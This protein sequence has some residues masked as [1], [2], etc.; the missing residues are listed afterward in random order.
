VDDEDDAVVSDVTT[1]QRVARRV[2]N[3]LGDDAVTGLRPEREAPHLWVGDGDASQ[4]GVTAFPPGQPLDPSDPL[5]H[6]SDPPA[7]SDREREPG[8]LVGLSAGSR[9]RSLPVLGFAT[10]GSRRRLHRLH[11]VVVG[12]VVA[13]GLVFAGWSLLRARAVAV[14]VPMAVT[15]TTAGRVPASPGTPEL[16]P[17]VGTATRS[18][19][20]NSQVVVHVLGAVRRPGLVRLP[21]GTRVQDAIRAAGGLLPRADAAQLNLARPL[22]DGQQVIIGTRAHPR[23]EIRDGP[24]GPTGPAGS[25]GGPRTGAATSADRLDLNQATAAEL[26]GLPGVGPITAERILAWRAEHGR[27]TRL[28]ELQEIEGIGPKTFARLASHLYV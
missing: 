22:S 3:L 10:S 14:T 27:F 5:D 16:D 9:L 2:V 21:A 15:T 12:V 20:P 28:E 23:G 17:T 7:Q 18:T 24:T 4:S 6:P 19:G 13:V 8:R 1:S 11:L 25:D 26:D